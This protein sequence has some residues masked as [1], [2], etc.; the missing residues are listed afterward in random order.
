M[1]IVDM[2]KA[3][4]ETVK[5][6]LMDLSNQRIKVETEITKLSEYIKH[7]E[8]VISD[9]EHVNKGDDLNFSVDTK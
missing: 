2:A 1:N 3:H 4:I 8:A 5:N 9:F 7:G 6:A